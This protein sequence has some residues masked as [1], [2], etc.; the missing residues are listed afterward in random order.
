MRLLLL[1][2][3]G[4]ALNAGAW[5]NQGSSRTIYLKHKSV[6]ALGGLA[7]YQ[8]G[9]VSGHPKTGLAMAWG[10]GVAY[11]SYEQRHGGRFRAGDIAWTVAPATLAFSVRW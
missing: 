6:H 1:L 8:L 2:I 5:L 10:I 4:S 3:L 9:K 11:E 7:V